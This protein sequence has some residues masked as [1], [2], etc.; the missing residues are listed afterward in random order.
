[1]QKLIDNYIDGTFIE[2][3]SNYYRVYRAGHPKHRYWLANRRKDIIKLDLYD[4]YIL[5][6][7][8]P[9][10]TMSYD[11]SGY[12]LSDVIE[13]L[14]II[15]KEPV[16][17]KWAPQCII[18][19][20]EDSMKNYHGQIDNL[21]VMLP[22]ELRWTTIDYWTTWWIQQAKYLKSDSQIFFSF[23]ENRLIRNRLKNK[24]SE[25][26]DDWLQEMKQ[27]GFKLKHYSYDPCPVD[28]SIINLKQVPEITDPVNGNLKIH[29]EYN[30]Q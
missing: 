8:I 18:D 1:M 20:G 3:F 21:I 9:G 14:I 11:N 10:T 16:V 22:R 6:N 7:L 5:E 17:L 29:W 27:H 23:R 28:D 13:N 26:M 19:T 2:S 12:Y 30:V 15:E 24:L 4:Q 25:V